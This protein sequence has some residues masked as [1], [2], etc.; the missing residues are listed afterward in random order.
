MRLCGWDK[1]INFSRQFAGRLPRV[2]TVICE[3]QNTAN[4]VFPALGYTT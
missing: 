1:G 2:G 3:P 4:R